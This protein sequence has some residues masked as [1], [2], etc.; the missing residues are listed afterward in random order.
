MRGNVFSVFLIGALLFFGVAC[1][2]PRV[3]KEDL[4]QAAAAYYQL[5]VEYL[6]KGEYER[7]LLELRKAQATD[8]KKVEVYNAEGLV[9]YYTSRN[10][11]AEE[12][13]RKALLMKENYSEAYINL[14]TLYAREGKCA[15]AV[16]QFEK[17]LQ[18]PFYKTPA[19]AKE[20]LGL[21]YQILGQ[22]RK[23]E[24]S[25]K[26]AIRLDPFLFRA[27]F[28]LGKLY[29][30]NNRIDQAIWILSKAIQRH[31]KVEGD[32]VNNLSL[33]YLHYWLG[34]SYFKNAD[35][36]NARIHFREV[37]RLS[38]ETKLSEDAGKYLELLQ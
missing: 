26:E 29:Y 22:F 9:Y 11:E 4:E 15:Q 35:R 18:N 33:A 12:A 25:F 31:P 24:A 5:G 20:N 1:L 37:V 32:P 8:P 38:S 28:D 2:E 13:F 21:C 7:A 3:R 10:T 30:K 19:K 6:N 27:Y 16:S 14:G 36:D 34:L 23:A 17:A